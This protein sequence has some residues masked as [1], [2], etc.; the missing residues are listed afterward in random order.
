M[1]SKSR[2]KGA[3]G[4]REAANELSRITGR[5]WRRAVGQSRS[6]ADA[7]DVEREDGATE[8]WCEVKRQK[9]PSW[10]SAMKQA[11]EAAPEGE[12]C[13]VLTRDDHGAW[14]LHVE[15]AEVWSLHRLAADAEQV[16]R[17]EWTKAYK[18]SMRHAKGE[19]GD[20]E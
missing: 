13:W 10:R 16:R 19:G 12:P 9:Q 11:R 8:A 17:R 1:G 3:S 5:P 18:E 14:V 6:G 4:E 2:R 20:G 7:P 15:L